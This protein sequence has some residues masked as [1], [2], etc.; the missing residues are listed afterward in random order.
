MARRRN[1]KT[2]MGEVENRKGEKGIKGKRIERIMEEWR[3]KKGGTD[4]KEK[5]NQGKL[6]G[7]GEGEEEWWWKRQKA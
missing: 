4:E 1:G 7:R 3:R 6:A 2:W 5:R